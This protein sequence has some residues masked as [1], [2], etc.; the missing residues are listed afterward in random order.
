MGTGKADDWN[1]LHLYSLTPLRARSSLNPDV[2]II[3]YFDSHH[4]YQ[5]HSDRI[6]SDRI[7]RASTLDFWNRIPACIC[8]SSSRIVSNQ[9]NNQPNNQSINQ[10]NNYQNNRNS[11]THTLHVS[12]IR[13]DPRIMRLRRDG[14][15]RTG[16]VFRDSAFASRL[17]NLEI[18]NSKLKLEFGFGFAG[19]C[20]VWSW[21]FHGIDNDDD[22]D[23]DYAG[24]S[25]I[26]IILGTH[27][28]P[29]RTCRS[30][31]ARSSI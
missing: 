22:D 23:D 25:F 19:C 28:R 2:N 12:L 21:V 13:P 30:I 7:R 14:P 31:R 9:I 29:H 11:P 8:I 10:P 16:R 27:P 20:C 6:G 1:D 3:V 17:D 15:F 26:V 24:S 5:S 4:R 18:P